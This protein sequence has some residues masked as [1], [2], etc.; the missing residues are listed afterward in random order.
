MSGS[1]KTR[2]CLPKTMP[3]TSFR[4]SSE[5]APTSAGPMLLPAKSKVSQVFTAAYSSSALATEK[6]ENRISNRSGKDNREKLKGDFIRCLSC[7]PSPVGRGVGVTALTSQALPFDS[8]PR[9]R[10][11]NSAKNVTDFV[12]DVFVFQIF[13]LDLFQL[14]QKLSLF[15]RQHCR[16]HD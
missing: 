7:F 4:S 5:S 15:T 1:L 2:P 9:G 8:P 11:H 16:R 12:G 14:F 13:R 10:G 6:A 3:R